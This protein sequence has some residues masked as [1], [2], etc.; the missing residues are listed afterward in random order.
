M[1]DKEEEKGEHLF[2]HEA[3]VRLKDVAKKGD[4]VT[5]V[6]DF[7]DDLVRVTIDG[8][9]FIAVDPAKF[10]YETDATTLGSD[11]PKL[12]RSLL[13]SVGL[14]SLLRSLWGKFASS[15]RRALQ[16]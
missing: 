16:N 9:P 6:I 11:D 5:E 8:I 4:R 14:C 3:Y 7:T 15:L 2:T 13:Q 1:T 10:E 12:L